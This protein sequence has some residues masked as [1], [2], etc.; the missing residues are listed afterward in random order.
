MPAGRPRT[1]SFSEE[2]MIE[3]GKDMV[4]YVTE[5]KDTILHLSEWYTIK[6]MFTYKEWKT[7][8]QRLEFIPYYEQALR[9]V[10]YKYLD[11]HSN[12]RD[13]I[14]QRWQRIYFG[15]LKEGE[16][17]DADAEAERKAKALKGEARAAEEE[18]QKVLDEVQ[19]NRKT[20]K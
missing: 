8:I 16:D 19:R 13:G 4:K 3:L 12:V 11:K 14:S 20:I 9:I 18:K 2:E 7:F 15:D 1:V 5:H 6:K 17:A 10:G